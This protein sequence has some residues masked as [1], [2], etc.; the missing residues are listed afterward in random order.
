MFPQ[1][2]ER[3]TVEHILQLG[4]DTLKLSEDKDA[5]SNFI[6]WEEDEDEECDYVE[7]TFLDNAYEKE[8]S[9][10]YGRHYFR[11]KVFNHLEGEKGVF[12]N[13]SRKLM[14]EIAKLEP[15]ADK[16][17]RVERR[18]AGKKTRYN[19]IPPKASK[20]RKKGKAVDEDE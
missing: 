6:T 8:Y 1:T 4:G 11:F 5:M 18:G 15:Y 16:R 13:G 9:Q 17:I 20:P 19:I 14:S 12:S 10:E 2:E 3:Q 7:I